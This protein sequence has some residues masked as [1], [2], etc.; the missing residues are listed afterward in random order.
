[1][2]AFYPRAEIASDRAVIICPGGGYRLLSIDKE[3]YH[4][5]RWLNSLGITAYVLKYRLT[6]PDGTGYHYPAQLNDLKKAIQTVRHHAG[7]YHINPRKIGVMGFSAG[8]HLASTL[9]THF[10]SG[11]DDAFGPVAGVSCRPD[12]MILV[13]PHISLTDPG[14]GQSYRSNLLGADY[15]PELPLLLSNEKQVT[16]QTPPTF[17]VHAHDDKTVPSTPSVDFYLALREAGV[18]AQLHVFDK[19]GHGFGLGERFEGAKHW[20]R[21]CQDWMAGLD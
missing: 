21:L 14:T 3:G 11:Q 12:F 10:D 2:T 1:L 17:L 18:S 19:G 7:D 5:A 20:P 9:G 16:D 6:R 4:I 13:Y 15:D 8:G